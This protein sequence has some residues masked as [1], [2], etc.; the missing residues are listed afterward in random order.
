MKMIE[1][2]EMRGMNRKGNAAVHALSKSGSLL[3]IAVLAFAFLM[4]PAHAEKGVGLK[5]FTENENVAE[6]SMH[7]IDYG[8]YNPWNTDVNAVLKVS[9]EFLQVAE[10]KK[11][12]PVFVKAATASSAALPSRICFRIGDTYEEECLIGNWFCDR[13]CPKE[14]REYA[15][16]VVVEEAPEEST[17]GGTGAMVTFSVAAPL[18]LVVECRDEKRDLTPLYYIGGIATGTVMFT[19]AKKYD[20]EKKR[21]KSRTVI[22]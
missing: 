1:E 19:V 14:Q 11:S 12:E 16:Q 7:C 21:R 18:R 2:K 17:V 13:T 15:G 8:I 4:P 10:M 6:E 5:W 9:G 20:P 3:V 22:Q